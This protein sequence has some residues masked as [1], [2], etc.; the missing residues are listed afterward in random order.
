MQDTQ[1]NSDDTG[2]LGEVLDVIKNSS[3]G[4]NTDSIGIGFRSG[5]PVQR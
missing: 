3:E 5:L 1:A 2:Q 4:E